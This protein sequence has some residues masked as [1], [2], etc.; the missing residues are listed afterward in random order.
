MS[1]TIE[2]NESQK[3]AVRT[4]EG[5][6]LVIAGAGSGKTR[7]LT[8]RIRYLVTEKNVPPW[9]ILAFTFT[10]KAANEMKERLERSNPGISRSLWVG[11][12]HATGVRIL[13]RSGER[14]GVRRD[15]SIYDADDSLNLVK[16]IM[17]RSILDARLV[18]SPRSLRD[19]ISRL[20]NEL[21]TPDLAADQAAN[22][23][24]RRVAEV[25]AEYE[26]E[27]KRAN[28]LDFDDLIVKVVELFAADDEIKSTY[29]G[30]FHYVLVDEFQDTN[31]IQMAMIHDLAS[32]HHNLFV[33]GDDDQSIYSWRGAKVEHILQFEEL[34]DDTRVVRLEQNYRSTK[35]IL[36]AANHVISNNAGRMGKN[37][38]TNGDQGEKVQ[39]L[40]SMD[41]E[42]EA[43]NVLQTV[44]TCREDG[45][46]LKDI[47]I[48]YR[49]NAQSRALEEVLKLGSLPYQIIG[50]VRFYERMEV[51]DLLAYCKTLVNPA[52]TINLRRI[53][54]V[55]RRGI[56]K[57]S[58]ERL[59]TESARRNLSVV[60]L[61]R[62]GDHGLP[63]SASKRCAAF[64]ALYDQLQKIASEEKAP[65]ALEAVIDR[66]AYKQYLKEA[67][68]DADARVENVDE[69]VNAAHVFAESAE[70]ASL[71]AFLEEVALVADVDSLDTEQGQLTLMTLHNA[72]GLEFDCVI[73][74][75]LEE[76]LF[77]HF[78]SM[79]SDR[80][81]EEERRLFY[82][83]MTRARKRL[84]LS[85]A[86]MRRKMGHIEGVKPSRFLYEVPEH[87]LDHT[88]GRP[89]EPS[90]G[91]FGDD[92][93]PY[94]AGGVR[95]ARR[96]DADAHAQV[97]PDY[98]SF[99]QEVV[100]GY[101]VGM[102]IQH[103]AFGLGV[104]RKVEGRGEQTR[105]TVIFDAG[106][107]RKF[108]AHFAPMHPI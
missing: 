9:N 45:F 66:V 17:Q 48:L 103:D 69:L 83:G 96:A 24:E 94:V 19:K 42:T 37:L 32:T 38:W 4:T 36:E 51:R 56:G 41:E 33:V 28:A 40:E 54:N 6:V 5:P 90:A 27:L 59:E 39:L 71:R 46:N 107:E 8:E 108:L 65:L 61:L 97:Q 67:Y 18:K 7:V 52:D 80:E 15:F 25:Y 68:P 102:R 85:Y 74:A 63:T 70:D 31:P 23:V 3:Q 21:V 58:F 35:I 72:K 81:L 79:N 10:N 77:P 64:I 20:K 14:V 60:D 1:T 87:C 91:L 2:L 44:T 78:N 82:V 93:Q 12:F 100:P 13:R 101:R 55:P 75:G 50:S 84:Y 86:N 53:I 76:G 29:S 22:H 98:E 89:V 88:V 16:S 104:V 43:V 95:G 47:A 73:V 92:F 11:T 34:Y 62:A 105:V 49:T 106:G 57:T 30:R 26:R 99:S